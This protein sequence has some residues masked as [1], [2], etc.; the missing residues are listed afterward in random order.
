MWTLIVSLWRGDIVLPPIFIVL[1]VSKKTYLDI[2]MA[3]FRPPKQW[4][5]GENETIST[6][7]S[8]KSNIEYHLSLNNEFSSFLDSSF[9]WSKQSVKN[10]GLT[11][12]LVKEVVTTTAVQRNIQ[13]ERMLGI[14][15]Q[16][17]PPLLRNDIIKRSLSLNWIWARLRKYYQFEQNE[18]NFLKISTIRRQ[19]GERYET[20]YQRLVAH[21]EDNLLSPDANLIHDGSIYDQVEEM[22]PTVERLLVYIWLNLIDERLPAYISRIYA[23]DLQRKT[24]KEIQPQIC[25][26]MDSLLTEMNTLRR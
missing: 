16:F 11:D 9:T 26:A 18:G 22:S 23:N 8:W 5:L 14:I 6:Y 25:D 12:I 13:L 20:L 10:R 19:E 24:I 2:Q 17:S 15:A 4:T 21:I 7:A 3:F 1:K